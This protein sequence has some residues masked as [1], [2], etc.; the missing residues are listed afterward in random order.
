MMRFGLKDKGT[1]KTTKLRLSNKSNLSLTAWMGHGESQPDSS[2]KGNASPRCYIKISQL[3]GAPD[4]AGSTQQPGVEDYYYYTFVSCNSG[5]LKMMQ[6]CVQDFVPPPSSL[7]WMAPFCTHVATELPL[8][9]VQMTAVI[10]GGD[11]CRPGSQ[12]LQHWCV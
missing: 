9:L 12:N 11:S 10:P 3:K 8:L 5:Y 7:E 2:R 4:W 6:R 1:N